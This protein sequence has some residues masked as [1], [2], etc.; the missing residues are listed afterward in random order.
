[1]TIFTFEWVAYTLQFIGAYSLSLPHYIWMNLIM[2]SRR[3]F[4]GI[5]PFY[6]LVISGIFS[7]V[8]QYNPAR[9]FYE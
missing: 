3:D 1:M 9:L 5:I 6:G 2:T 8:N 4:N 7:L